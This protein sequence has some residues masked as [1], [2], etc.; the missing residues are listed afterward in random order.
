[1]RLN[2]RASSPSQLSVKLVLKEWH[3]SD[4]SNSLNSTASIVSQPSN[5]G[6][7]SFQPG[8]GRKLKVTIIEGKDLLTK[9]G[10]CDPYVKLH[11]GKVRNRRPVDS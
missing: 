3:Y 11:Y 9:S 6:S 7:S 5:S 2:F 1:M 8:T 10:K 4:G